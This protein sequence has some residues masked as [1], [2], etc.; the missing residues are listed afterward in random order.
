MC[1]SAN[2]ADNNAA[3]GNRVSA[4]RSARH[5]FRHVLEADIGVET[6]VGADGGFKVEAAADIG[7]GVEVR[8]D[9]GIKVES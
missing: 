5:G 2:W 9:G 6:E 7:V 8:A 4:V 3:K 1:L